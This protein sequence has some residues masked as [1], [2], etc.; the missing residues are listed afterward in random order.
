MRCPKFGN[1]DQTVDVETVL[2]ASRVSGM[3]K[4]R[5]NY[6]GNPFRPD[7]STP[8]THLLYG[9]LVGAL[10]N[11]RKAREMLNYGV[12]PLY[13]EATNGLGYRTLS[14]RKLR[15]EEF[16]GGYASHLGLDPNYFRG[17]SLAEKG[18]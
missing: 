7:F 2:L 4:A 15:Y 12:D 6:L 5:K 9:A 8:S 13:G 3:L 17:R 18:L 16:N 1:N 11:G 10:P 14:T